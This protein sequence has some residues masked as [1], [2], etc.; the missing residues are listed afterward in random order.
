MYVGIVITYNKG[1]GQS[2]NVANPARG[3]E[4]NISLSPF[5][6]ENLAARDGSD[7]FVPRRPAHLYTQAESGAD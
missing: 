1:K 5:A 6:S 3:Q 7:S 4:M 2:G